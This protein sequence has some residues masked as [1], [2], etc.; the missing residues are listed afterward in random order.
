MRPCRESISRLS[1]SSFT[2]MIVLEKVSATATY[3]L[4][5]GGSPSARQMP[6]PITEVNSTWPSPVATAT[7]PSVRTRC[8]SSFNPT[9]NNRI[10]MPSSARRS[11]CS[12]ERAMS[13]PAGPA[14]IP[15]AMKLTISG[16]RSSRPSS[17]TPAARTSSAATS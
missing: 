7:G 15:T 2:M 17:P 3:R 1:D 5:I 16:W 13:R 8:R 14:R 6:K 11:M 4:A 9:R 10:A 12:L